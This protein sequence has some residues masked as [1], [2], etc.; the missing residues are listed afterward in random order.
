[1]LER[2]VDFEERDITR[3]PP[4]EREWARFLGPLPVEE[5]VSR[6][7]TPFK[8]L[9]YEQALPPR[10]RFLQDLAKNPALVRRPILLGPNGERILG[11]D[12]ERYTK[13]FG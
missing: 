4:D 13:I 12:R 8:Q 6:R 7:S 10:G 5:T 3:D 9:G 11:F 2:Q 1:M